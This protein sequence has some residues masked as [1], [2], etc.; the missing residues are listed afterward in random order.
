MAMRRIVGWLRLNQRQNV[1]GVLSIL[2]SGFPVW[3]SEEQ[4]SNPSCGFTLVEILVTLAILSAVLP[5]LLQI[6]TSATRNQALSD[7]NTTALYLLKFRMAEI[8]MSGYPDVG[9]ATGDFGDNSRYQWR[10]VVED[11]ESEQLQGVLRV[12]VTVS[13]Q[14]LGKERSM[15]MNTF[16]SDRQIQKTQTQ[17]GGQPGIGPQ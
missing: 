5:A 11:I 2:K 16:I 7:D 10:S 17:Q 3:D 6:F 1:R 13:W 8:E 9:E 15:A 4:G 14:H 12:Q